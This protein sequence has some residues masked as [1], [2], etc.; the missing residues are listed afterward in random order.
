MKQKILIGC[1]VVLLVIAVAIGTLV[2]ASPYLVRRGKGWFTA[3]VAESKRLSAIENSWQPP[4]ENVQESW[5]PSKAGDWTRG[6]VF[7]VDS[8]PELDL[9]RPG[10]SGSYS[11]P[12]GR[13]VQVTIFA[14]NETEKAGLI[15]TATDSLATKLGSRTTT[16]LNN[17][18]TFTVNNTH[19]VITIGNRTHVVAGGNEHARLWWMNGWL[20]LF[21]ST[22]PDDP[23]DFAE[24]FISSMPHLE[25]AEAPE[26]AKTP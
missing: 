8:I 14:V 3:Q 16:H 18:V 9:P 23:A 4:A 15:K 11:N 5:F 20:F 22:G 13:A 19:S 6:A 17:H 10:V 24:A 7:R 12:N 21:R 26:P 1:G 25:T 2:I